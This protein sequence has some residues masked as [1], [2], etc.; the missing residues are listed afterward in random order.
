MAS[1]RRVVLP[2]L[3]GF[4]VGRWGLGHCRVLALGAVAG[5]FWLQRQ[6]EDTEVAEELVDPEKQ[7]LRL[8]VCRHSR[9]SMLCWKVKRLP[10]A[11]PGARPSRQRRGSQ[12]SERGD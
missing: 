6:N 2:L 5:V 12:F 3:I 4:S 8:E 11:Q 9:L 10:A 7:R 1:D